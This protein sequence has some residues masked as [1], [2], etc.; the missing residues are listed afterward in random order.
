MHGFTGEGRLLNEGHREVILP[1]MRKRT[2]LPLDM[3]R[4]LLKRLRHLVSSHDSGP[5]WDSLA[6]WPHGG[7]AA[8]E[9]DG[10]PTSVFM[11]HTPQFEQAEN[12]FTKSRKWSAFQACTPPTA[13]ALREV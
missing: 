1:E 12:K 10:L 2:G 3:P 13:G 5:S 6:A 4:L 7:K 9:S 8:A 11:T